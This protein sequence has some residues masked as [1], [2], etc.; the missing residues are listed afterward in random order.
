MVLYIVVI[1]I[2]LAFFSGMLCLRKSILRQP[3]PTAE[4]TFDSREKRWGMDMTDIRQAAAWFREQRMEEVEI[5]SFD[6]LQLHGRW[7]PA[8]GESRGRILLF[9]GYRSGVLEDLAGALPFYHG[10][11]YDLMIPDQRAH[12]DSEGKFIGFGVL[13]R[14]DCLSW[15]RY[16]ENRFGT[17]PTFLGGV[18]MGATTVLMAA[19]GSLPEDVKGVVADCGFTSPWEIVAHEGKRLLHLPPWPL[20]PLTSLLSRL[21]AGYGFR[22]YS[23]LDAMK[24]LQVPVLFIHGGVDNFVPTEMSRRNYEACRSEKELLIVPEADHGASFLVDG[25]RYRET[26]AGFLNRWN[27]S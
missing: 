10:L 9:H 15:L 7:L 4:E 5:L 23:T 3:I 16:L 14:R 20:V 26:V 18:S 27:P 24:T 6:G 8:E 19:G 11:G 22:D 1:L 13:E 2:L 17:A 12:G 25:E 21:L